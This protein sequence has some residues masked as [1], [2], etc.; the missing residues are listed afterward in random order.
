MGLF[1]KQPIRKATGFTS[2]LLAQLSA[3]LFA[4]ASTR[5]RILVAGFDKLRVAI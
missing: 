3:I 5:V 4:F 2:K 1:V